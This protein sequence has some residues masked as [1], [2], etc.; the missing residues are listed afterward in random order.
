[1]RMRVWREAITTGPTAQGVL[2]DHETVIIRLIKQA[3]TQLEA[4]VWS[5]MI[6]P[7]LRAIH[8][9]CLHK[10]LSQLVTEKKRLK[11]PSHIV[12]SWTL[13]VKDWPN[14]AFNYAVVNSYISAAVE[15]SA[16]ILYQNFVVFE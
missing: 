2:D 3:Q 11:H 12:D 4:A 6:D 8:L 15:Y 1:M 14:M 9:V 13:S 7:I 10:A 5:C 16:N